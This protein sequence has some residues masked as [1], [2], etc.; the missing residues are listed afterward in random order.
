LSLFGF[1]TLA[2]G[3][4]RQMK[5]KQRFSKISLDVTNQLSKMAM[6][7][8]YNMPFNLYLRARGTRAD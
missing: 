4:F 5:K 1:N 7:T 3:S 8:E 6:V 2:A